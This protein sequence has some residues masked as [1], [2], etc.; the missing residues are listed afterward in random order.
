MSRYLEYFERAFDAS[1]TEKMKLENKPYVAYSETEGMAYTVIPNYV[2]FT[3]LENNCSIGFYNNPDSSINPTIEYSFDKNTWSTLT[4]NVSIE[5]GSKM[6][7]RGINPDGISEEGDDGYNYF[8]GEGKFNISG[9]IMSIIDYGTMPKTMVGTFSN[10]F[11][12]HM[13]ELR[14]NFVD[15]VDASNLILSA[16]TL[17]PYCYNEMF[18]YCTSLTTAPELPATTLAD[19]CYLYMFEGCTSLTTASELPVTILAESCCCGMFSGCTSL[20]TAPELSVTTLAERCYYGMF[21]GCT[22]LTTVPVLP[23]T[24]LA[25]SCYEDMFANCTSLTTTPELPA[26]TLVDKCYYRMFRN[27]DSLNHIKCLATDISALDCT[28]VWVDGVSSIGTFVKHPSMNDWT[29]GTGG[30]PESWTIENAD[31]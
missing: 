30:I 24:E 26:T 8:T 19:Y 13:D 21:Q 11:G 28:G 15:I 27:C 10:L 22:S 16:T 31:I 4:D 12:G 9:N 25:E 2:T 18:Y 17:T 20:T 7:C 23:A 6:Y 29:T 3:A 14:D 5:K 1:V